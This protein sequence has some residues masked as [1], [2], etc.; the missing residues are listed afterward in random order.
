M[1]NTLLTPTLVANE[2]LRILMNRL[3]VL[4]SVWRGA[5]PDISGKRVG[6]TINIRSVATF[7]PI[8]FRELSRN[9]MLLKP[10]SL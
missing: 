8:T 7:L 3:G 5:E 4:K 2:A 10:L 9:K 6:D 1:A